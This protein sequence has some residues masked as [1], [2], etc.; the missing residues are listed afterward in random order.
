MGAIVLS[1]WNADEV[2]AFWL[3]TRMR[4][5]LGSTNLVSNYREP[6]EIASSALI[7]ASRTIAYLSFSA[8]ALIALTAA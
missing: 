1:L 2:F 8:R 3:R 5:R 7:A 4:L 6:T